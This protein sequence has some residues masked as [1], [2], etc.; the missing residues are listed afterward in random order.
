MKSS[1]VVLRAVAEQIFFRGVAVKIE[2]KLYFFSLGLE[3]FYEVC[4]TVD[5]W[6]QKMSYLIKT[7][8]KISP[9]ETRS[10]VA[11]YYSVRIDHGD[12]IKVGR[13][14]KSLWNFALVKQ[15][16]DEPFKHVRRIAFSRM[17]SGDDYCINFRRRSLFFCNGD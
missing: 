17:Y 16:V 10:I 2:E 7:T 11:C 9:T 1:D 13:S 15:R 3:F 12:D 6:I 14:K 8:I 4:Q 5:L